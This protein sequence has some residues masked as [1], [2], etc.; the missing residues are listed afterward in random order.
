VGKVASLATMRELR[1]ARAE[2]RRLVEHNT[3]RKLTDRDPAL[4]AQLTS[5]A[6]RA[7]ARLRVRNA[8]LLRHLAPAILDGVE[9]LMLSAQLTGRDTSYADALGL[10]LSDLRHASVGP[11]VAARLEARLAELVDQAV[12]TESQ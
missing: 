7:A 9:W 3:R 10:L 6:D 5:Q 12:E 11:R 4:C 2:L 8:F 1:A